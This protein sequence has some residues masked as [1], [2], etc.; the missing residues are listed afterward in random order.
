MNREVL[1][2]FL[3][4][5]EYQYQI[6]DIRN[7][8]KSGSRVTVPKNWTGKAIIILDAPIAKEVAL[9][10]LTTKL[11]SAI[12]DCKQMR[13]V[14]KELNLTCS[15]IDDEM[16]VKTERNND[17][18]NRCAYAKKIKQLTKKIESFYSEDDDIALEFAED[19][20]EKKD[21]LVL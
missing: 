20:M 3:D 13:K 16:L 21:G 19:Y 17:V 18:C 12:E 2:K 9:R 7:Y 11:E 8:D 14:A 4:D 6:R 5:N 15:K 1:L 10:N